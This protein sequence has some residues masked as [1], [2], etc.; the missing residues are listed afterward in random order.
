MLLTEREY[1]QIPTRAGGSRTACPSYY[2]CYNTQMGAA[3]REAPRC[4]QIASPC[5]D[6]QEEEL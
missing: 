4:S 5:A 1:V 3:R 6:T 2:Y